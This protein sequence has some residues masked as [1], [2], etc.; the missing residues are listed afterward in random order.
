VAPLAIAAL[1]LALYTV[2]HPQ[3]RRRNGEPHVRVAAS[4]NG[5]RP[6]NGASDATT[7]MERTPS[8]GP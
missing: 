4:T 3:V 7:P 8:P 2:L 5:A 6:A 1:G